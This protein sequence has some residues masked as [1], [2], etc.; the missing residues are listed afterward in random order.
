MPRAGA[1]SISRGR[2]TLCRSCSSTRPIPLARPVRPSCPPGRSRRMPSRSASRWPGPPVA[3][4]R[5]G[6]GRYTPTPDLKGTYT[7]LL[8]GGSHTVTAAKAGYSPQTIAD[9]AVDDSATTQ[10]DF[11]LPGGALVGT[12]TDSI[13]AQPV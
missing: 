10:L 9:I 2:S 1:M 8:P 4:A 5:V 6:D 7:L 13:S 12:V 11:T 3:G